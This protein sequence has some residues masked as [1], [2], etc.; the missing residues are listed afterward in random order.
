MCTLSLTSMFSLWIG[1]S[2]IFCGAITVM[3]MGYEDFLVLQWVSLIAGKLENTT[4][5]QLHNPAHVHTLPYESKYTLI[6][7]FGDRALTVRTPQGTSVSG[8]FHMNIFWAKH[9][10]PYALCFSVN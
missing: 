2:G 3:H 9:Q 7:D 1:M 10:A 4:I 5:M 8:S 6:W